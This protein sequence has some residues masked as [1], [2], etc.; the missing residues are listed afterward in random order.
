MAFR[1]KLGRYVPADSP[2]HKLDPRIK[3]VCGLAFMVSVFFIQT[4]VQL[5]FGWLCALGLVLASRIP[6]GKMLDSIRP[7]IAVLLVLSVFNLLLVT[8]G[9]VLLA[10]GP[11]RITT[12][13]LWAAVNY[14]LRLV[15]AIIAASLILLTTTPTQLTDAF[16]A[17]LAPLS[18]I[19]L[20]GHEI[21]MVFSLMLRFI[22][23]IA[24]EASAIVDAQTARGGALAEGSLPKRIRAVVPIIV[25][26]LAS[27]LRHANGLSRALDARCYEGG[28]GRSHWLPL[29]LQARDAVAVVLTC[30]YIAAL[31]A[32]GTWR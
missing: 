2:I 9:D 17:L 4:P 31:L 27:S 29:R 14:S 13:G 6:V 18:R 22:P 10:V 8:T 3:I 5:V 7:I 1:I 24:D 20:P 28:S 26:L 11:I 30:A 15:V 25:A 32:L 19:G 23:T 21:A 12:D 16:D